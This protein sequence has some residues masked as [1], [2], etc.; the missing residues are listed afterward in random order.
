M[1]STFLMGRESCQSGSNVFDWYPH[2]VHVRH[3]LSC[4]TKMS[5]TRLFS[6]DRYRFHVS[7][8]FSDALQKNAGKVRHLSDWVL[9]FW[10]GSVQTNLL[11]SRPQVSRMVHQSCND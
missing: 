11:E 7:R 4:P 10:F 2:T 5:T 6:R 1:C 8:A 3:D 9:Q